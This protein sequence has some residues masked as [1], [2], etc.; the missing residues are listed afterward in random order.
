MTTANGAA[1]PTAKDGAYAWYV[2]GMLTLAYAVGFI[3]RQ[4]L[5]LLVEPVK[6]DMMLSDTQV[7]LLQGFAFTVAYVMMGPLFGRWIDIGNRR[8]ILFVSVALWSLFTVLCGLSREYWQLFGARMG[9][10]GAEACLLPAAWSILSD[11][12]SKKKLPR[13]MS[14]LLMGPYLGGG[15][16]LIFG[17]LVLAAVAATGTTALP[18]LGVLAPWQIAFVAVG[19]PGF[20]VALLMLTIREPT[21]AG[22]AGAVSS[23][24]VDARTFTLREIGAFLWSKRTFYGAFYGGMSLH[25]IVLYALPAWVPAFLVRR[26]DM[27]P[28]AI[29]IEYGMLVLIVGSLGVLAGPYV[30]RYIERRG[31]ADAPFRTPALAALCVVPFAIALPFCDT[32]WKAMAVIAGATFFY[33]LPMAMAASALQIVTPNRMR[34]LVSSFYVFT[35][36]VVG[37]GLAPTIIAAMTDFVFGDPSMV[38]WSLAFVCAGAGLTASALMF[39]GLKAFRAAAAELEV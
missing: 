5:N 18:L 33:S 7:S 11:Y 3:D 27:T 22:T 26:F 17:G 1:L 4:I 13:A 12:F 29:G 36:S 35:V 19:V 25:V 9:V 23:A 20:A 34:G 14:V 8:N 6:L 31:F 21:R 16:A 37:L 38:G 30:G 39:R 10:G 24:K 32:Y 2:V 28:T 15:L